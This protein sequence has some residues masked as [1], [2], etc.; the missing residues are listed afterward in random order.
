MPGYDQRGP[1][2]LRIVNGLVDLGAF[3]VQPNEAMFVGWSVPTVMVAGQQYQ[4]SVTMRNVG[5]TTWTAGQFYR[6][7]SQDPQD[8]TTWGLNRV[9]LPGPVAPGQEVTFTFTVT[10]PTTPGTYHFQ[11]RMVEEG[12]QWF[13]A[14]T[15]DLRVEVIT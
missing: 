3:E 10:A 1:G 5:F 9:Q 7:G 4:V 12:V 14:F 15:P 8:N 13:G 2:H 11:W 6:L